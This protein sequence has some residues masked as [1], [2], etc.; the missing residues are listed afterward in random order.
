MNKQQKKVKFS[1]NM[2]ITSAS[3]G[4]NTVGCFDSVQHFRLD[5]VVDG[6]EYL[7]DGCGH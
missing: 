6:A 7:S 5:D 2:H 4:K 3:N 1:V